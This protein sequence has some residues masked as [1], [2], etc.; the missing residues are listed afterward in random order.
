MPAPTELPFDY[1]YTDGQLLSDEQAAAFLLAEVNRT[2]ISYGLDPLVVSATSAAA[3]CITGSMVATGTVTIPSSCRAGHTG[4][5][6]VAGQAFR[7][8]PGIASGPAIS[9]AAISR[10]STKVP[11]YIRA[12]PGG[13]ISVGGALVASGAPRRR[14]SMDSI[15]IDARAAPTSARPPGM[16][17]ASAGAAP[18]PAAGAAPGAA[19]RR[20]GG[21]QQD[22]GGGDVMRGTL[23]KA[24]PLSRIDG[25]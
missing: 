19:V 9:V 4:G 7:V 16:R 18:S 14:G 25:R 24:P 13:S 6:L 21:L 8:T 22:F 17:I 23:V 1:A 5:Y 15:F 11:G 2:R 12:A 20:V 3:T 10:R